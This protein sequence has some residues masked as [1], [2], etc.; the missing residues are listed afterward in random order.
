M[1]KTINRGCLATFFEHFHHKS[2]FIEHVERIRH[3]TLPKLA[4]K[5]RI[6]LVN[7]REKRAVIGR[8]WY[9]YRFIV[10]F[11]SYIRDLSNNVQLFCLANF[12]IIVSRIFH[13]F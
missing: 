5:R 12:V 11:S 7:V 3:L 10:K 2:K 9:S 13:E 6:S 8:P 1:H 4:E